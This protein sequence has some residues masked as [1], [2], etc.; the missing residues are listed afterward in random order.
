M[1]THH[2]S[3]NVWA[4]SLVRLLLAQLRLAMSRYSGSADPGTSPLWTKVPKYWKITYPVHFEFK[5]TFGDRPRFAKKAAGGTIM[6][7]SAFFAQALVGVAAL[8]SAL[9][10]AS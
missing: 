6:V 4:T 3:P 8:R 1:F 10:E 9:Q 2:A 7:P 5:G